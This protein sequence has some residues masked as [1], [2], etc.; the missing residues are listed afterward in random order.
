[1][2]YVYC[3]TYSQVTPSYLCSENRG[4]IETAEFLSKLLSQ[5]PQLIEVN[6]ASNLMPIDSL[7]IICSALKIAKGIYVV[8][9]S[10]I[11]DPCSLLD[12]VTL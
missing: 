10:S 4:G 6:A 3:G 11:D 5:A 7:S 8:T 1:M 2:L 12:G 9:V